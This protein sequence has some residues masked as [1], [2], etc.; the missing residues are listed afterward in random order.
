MFVYVYMKL[1]LSVEDHRF[2]T[3]VVAW[4]VDPA[5]LVNEP[6]KV[7]MESAV[8]LMRNRT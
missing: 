6:L 1:A 4:I 2:R 5:A 8:K 3:V 7:Q